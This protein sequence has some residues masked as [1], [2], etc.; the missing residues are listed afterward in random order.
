LELVP[1]STIPPRN[2]P[3]QHEGWDICWVTQKIVGIFSAFDIFEKKIKKIEGV[4][5]NVLPPVFE[6]KDLEPPTLLN[7]WK[8]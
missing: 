4:P 7:S 6:L 5:I 8:N 3:F 2:T 1:G